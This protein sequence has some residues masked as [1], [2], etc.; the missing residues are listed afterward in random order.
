MSPIEQIRNNYEMKNKKFWFSS[1]LCLECLLWWLGD[2]LHSCIE[3]IRRVL[4]RDGMTP[5][6]VLF[7]IRFYSALTS[8]KSHLSPVMFLL[9]LQLKQN[10]VAP[11][12]IPRGENYP[13]RA[14]RDERA[15]KASLQ[16]N[17][18][19]ANGFYYFSHKLLLLAVRDT[20][21]A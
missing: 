18:R 17:A 21:W 5:W 14:N 15:I 7:P 4:I 1:T 16:K 11:E 12:R 3:H 2:V 10:L 9:W 20:N 13:W 19:T 6:S 8:P